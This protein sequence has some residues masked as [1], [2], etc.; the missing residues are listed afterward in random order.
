MIQ[1]ICTP[2]ILNLSGRRVVIESLIFQGW[3]WR[4]T[5]VTKQRGKSASVSTKEIKTMTQPKKKEEGRWRERSR[6][7]STSKGLS[8][9]TPVTC[10]QLLNFIATMHATFSACTRPSSFINSTSL[11]LPHQAKKHEK[12]KKSLSL[13]FPCIENA[14]LDPRR[15]NSRPWSW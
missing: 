15:H 13:L 1:Y 12:Q 9:C 3:H 14:R 11:P 10:R 2:N 4:W 5:S 8:T 6:W 7:R